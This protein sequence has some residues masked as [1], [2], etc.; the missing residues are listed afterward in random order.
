MLF[1]SKTLTTL[2]FDKIISMLVECA[3]T[4]GAKSRA[5]S[6]VPSNDYDLIV[7]RQRRT[8]DAK[9]LINSKGYPSFSADERVVSSADR[10]YKGSILS[11]TELLEI[12]SLL[13][14]ARLVLDYINTD[15][16]FDTSL[17]NIFSRLIANRTL[18]DKITRSIL[19]E[20]MIADEASPELAEIRRKIRI[21]NNKI[22]DTLQSYV[23]GVRLKYL[24]EN[25]VTMRNG[26]YVV[27]VKAEYRNEMKG[28]VHDT[29]A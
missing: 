25:I 11:P 3:S 19:S 16:L 1:T 2:E 24:Q 29:S 28:L 7:D 17:D 20:D 15:K 23:G 12:A 22:K 18:E 26:R 9:R 21:A 14:S 8:D 10:A 5:K 4:E 6:L 27:P 13:R